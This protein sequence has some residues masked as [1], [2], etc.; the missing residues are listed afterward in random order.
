[1]NHL[2]SISTRSALM[3]ASLTLLCL[4]LGCSSTGSFKGETTGTGVSL[5][6]KNYRVVK[7]EAEGRSYG[8]SLLGIIPFTSPTYA[9]AKM[10]LYNSVGE[11]LTGRAIALANQTED[12]SFT[13]LILFSIPRLTITADVIEFT[14][15]P[16][17][18]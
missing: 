16:A 9:S 15:E 6:H 13:Y 3:A 5:T 4:A 17:T 10:D 14:E 8:F 1:M 18:N 7:A 11:S 12:H 2:I